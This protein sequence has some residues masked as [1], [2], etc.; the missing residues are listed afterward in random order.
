[1]DV[2]YLV[3]HRYAD[4]FASQISN[5]ADALVCDKF[6]TPGMKSGKHLDRNTGV[7]RKEM[8]GRVVHT[9]VRLAFCDPHRVIDLRVPLH[10]AHVGKAFGAQ[11]FSRDVLSRPAV[12]STDPSWQSDARRFRWRL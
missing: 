11:Q 8:H 2:S 7:D 4:P 5:A 12:G 10:I 9:E 1:M 6:K 3:K